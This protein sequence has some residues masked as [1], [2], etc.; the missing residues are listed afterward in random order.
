MFGKNIYLDHI[1]KK[2]GGGAV[3][4]QTGGWSLQKI[5]YNKGQINIPTYLR[6]GSGCSQNTDACQD[7]HIA[8]AAM[9]DHMAFPVQIKANVASGMSTQT[10]LQQDYRHIYL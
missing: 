7:W 5:W 8:K 9:I 1:I 6:P 3:G 10:H 2:K 4:L